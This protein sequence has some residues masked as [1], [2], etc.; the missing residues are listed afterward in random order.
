M[1][2]L[3][4][5]VD[6]IHTEFQQIIPKPLSRAKGH[7]QHLPLQKVLFLLPS[8]L[9]P[10]LC[11][12]PPSAASG[13]AEL[14]SLAKGSENACWASAAAASDGTWGMGSAHCEF[15]FGFITKIFIQE[16]NLKC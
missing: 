3:D 1:K 11:P 4:I 14:A 13:A 16:I 7:Q 10:W 6:S 12:T 9:M 15:I 5:Q 2:D 8:L